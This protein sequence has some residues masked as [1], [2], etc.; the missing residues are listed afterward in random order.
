MAYNIFPKTGKDIENLKVSLN[1][2]TELENLLNFLKQKFKILDPIALDAGTF[3]KEKIPVKIIRTLDGEINL[4]DLSKKYNFLNL[5][6]GNGSRGKRGANNQ[7]NLFEKELNKDFEYYINGE[8]DKIKY[9]TA[10]KD[11]IALLSKDET[12]I[13]TRVDGGKNQKRP[14]DPDKM[15]IGKLGDIGHIVTDV[16]LTIKNTKTKKQKEIYLSLKTSPTVTFLNSWVT[17]FFP[18]KEMKKY[19]LSSKGKSILET[20][21]IDEM[22][23]C[24]I[25]NNYDPKKS[26]KNATKEIVK[27]SNYNKTKMK[28]FLESG[29]GYGYIYVHKLGKKVKVLDLREKSTVDKFVKIKGPIEVEYPK[30]GEAKRIDVKFK[31]EYLEFKMN[32]RNKQGKIYPSHIMLD[33]KFIK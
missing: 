29:I 11:I 26:K 24:A 12:I 15:I 14:L 32:I 9:K 6:F 1:I 25:F 30:N 21:G 13:A 10:V 4:K 7:G 19:K 16:T 22:K 8:D 31:T 33:Y 3:K 23:F 2:K 28:N 20:F 17:K 18:E 27:V 5:L